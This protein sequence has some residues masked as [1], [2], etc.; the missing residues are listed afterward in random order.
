M[1]FLFRTSVS[2]SFDKMFYDFALLT[3]NTFVK[4]IPIVSVHCSYIF[5]TKLAFFEAVA[6]LYNNHTLYNHNICH[7]HF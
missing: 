2:T 4:Q 5:I 3:W 6:P 1:Q 7:A